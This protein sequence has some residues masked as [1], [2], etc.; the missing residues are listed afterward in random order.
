MESRMALCN[1]SIEAGARAGLIAPDATTLEYVRGKLLAPKFNHWT[2]AE[3]YWKDLYSDIDASFDKVVAIN[4]S[5]VAPTVTWGTSPEQ[6]VPISGVIPD[7]EDFNDPVK[8]ESCCQALKYMNLQPGVPIANVQID[9]VFIGSCTNARLEDFRTAA[10]IL[11]GREISPSLKLALAVPGSGAIKRAAEKEGLDVIFKKAGFQWR[12]AGCSLCV[13]LNEDALLPFERCA[14]TSNRNFES[15]QGTSGR[16]HLVSPAVAAATAIKGTL[17]AP[18]L[19][20]VSRLD[21]YAD[22][23]YSGE[24][25]GTEDQSESESSDNEVIDRL[26]PPKSAP[27]VTKT[28]YTAPVKGRVAIIQR[29]NIDT[30]CIFPKQFCTTTERTG[31]G[32]ALFHNL[33]YDPDGVPNSDFVLNHAK[34]KGAAIL[35]ATG[36]NFGCGSSREHAVWAL[37]DFGFRCVMAPSFADIFYNNAFKNGLLLIKVNVKVIARVI[38][39]TSLERDIQIDLSEQTVLDESGVPFGRFEIEERRKVELLRGMDEIDITLVSAEGIAA[40]ERTRRAN[41]PWI[42]D[43]VQEWFSKQPGR[44]SIRQE[45]PRRGV[46][47]PVKLDW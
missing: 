13:G 24:S 22:L 31:L 6:V 11:K 5:Q 20:A 3:S 25:E 38:A 21:E 23:E 34:V 9:K 1:M 28:T 19:D 32:H 46:H 12:E 10:Q 14:S 2:E 17:S 4:A 41:R 37:Q 27:T 45:I 26:A 8:R 15:R 29:A 42:E 47:E 30:D 40:F 36:P 39:E 33:R 44:V 18:S 7:P 16:T 35:L 43:A